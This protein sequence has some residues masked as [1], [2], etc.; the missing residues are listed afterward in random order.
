MPMT[1]RSTLYSLVA[2]TAVLVGAPAGACAEVIRT[3]GTGALLE[4]MKRLGKAF[5]AVDGGS[6]L[7]VVPGLGSSGSIKAVADGALDFAVSGRP[8]KPEERALGLVEAPLLRTP[9]A[10]VTSAE[11][12]QS[13]RRGEVADFF[14]SG[15]ST[16][17]GGARVRVVLRPRGES[18][19]AHLGDTFPGMHAA[20]ETVRRRS[21]V[22]VA[23]TDQDNAHAAERIAGSLVAATYTQILTE[24]RKLRFVPIDG[25]APTT[26]ALETGSYPYG[27][28]FTFVFPARKSP[29][30]E[31]FIA[32]L[33]SP[34]AATLIRETGNVPVRP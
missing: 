12:P 28:T 18:D 8:L 9:F 1:C 26:E 21:D 29:T 27:K 4:T 34:E 2:A 6:E 13:L 11:D 25:V 30:T 31:R 24:G 23:A 33:R 17:K 14:A 16:W 32:F 22:P 10:L 19:T 15:T 5:A 3:G 7:E 20:I